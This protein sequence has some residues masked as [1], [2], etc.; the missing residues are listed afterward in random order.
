MSG[1]TSG[2][3]LRALVVCV[4]AV[5]ATGEG[6]TE[7]QEVAAA[8]ESLK[9]D[10]GVRNDEV[11]E[12]VV[13]GYREA[14]K[15]ALA[16]KRTSDVMVDA[17]NAE[18]VAKFPDSNLAESLQRLPGIAVDRDNGEGRTITVRGLG[19]DFTRVRLNGLE[20]LATAAAPDSGGAPNRSRGFD[21]N[22]F[23]S[24]LFS[25][26]EVRKTASADT[27]EGSLGATVD[28]QTPRPF[29]FKKDRYAFSAQDAYYEIG[30][31][32]RPRIAALMSQTW[33]DN[34]LGGAVS[35]A[36]NDRRSQINRY[37]RQ[38][39]SGDFLNQQAFTGVTPARG[40]FSAPVG[41]SFGNSVT[42]PSAIAA[43][44][45]SDPAAYA[46]LFPGPPYS[47]PGRFD[48]SI[49]RVPGL[50][51]IE[52]QNLTESRIGLTG[53]LQWRPT[54]RTLVSLDG[55]FSR[56]HQKSDISQIVDIGMNRNNTAAAYNVA[57][58]GTKV[59]DK[60]NLY[61]LCNSRP[62]T[63]YIA[64]LDCGGTEAVP[65]GVFP[66]YNG[67]TGTSFSTNPHNLDPYDYYNNPGSV[68]YPGAAAVAA[69]QFIYF[70]DALIGRPSTDVL[71]ANVDEGGTADYLMLRNMDARSATD[72][73]YF[74]TK[75]TQVSLN[76]Q[77]EITATLHADVL[78]GKSSSLNHNQAFLVEF[79]R[80]DSPEP[81]VYDERARGPMPSVSYGFDVADPNNWSIV[82]GYS[83][84]RHFERETDN[85]YSG[86]HLNFKWQ[87]VDA[88]AMEF[89][90]TRRDYKFSANEFRRPGGNAET[91]NP[92]LLELGVSAQAL[93]R[94]YN[95]GQGLQVPAGT[96]RSF[97]APDINAF[98]SILG[99]DCNCV[100][101]WGDWR[102]TNLTTPGNQFAVDELDNSYFVQ[103][104]WD[105]EVLRR[106]FFGNVGVRYAKTA[107]TSDGYTTNVTATG[108]RPLEASNNYHDLLPSLNAAY[109]L[110]EELILR[111][112]V[113]KVMSRPLLSNLAPSITNLT[114][115]STTGTTGSLT[116][117][118]PKVNPFRAT[119]YDFSVEW[120]FTPG[121]L[122]SGA[123]FIK[124]VTNYPQVVASAGSIQDLFTAEEFAQFLQTQP[125]P[126]TRAWLTSGGPNG[127]PGIYSIL[128]FKDSPG[129]TIKGYELTYQQNLT[130]LPWYF[131]NLGVQLNYTH[132]SSSLS[133]ILDPG[134]TTGPAPRPQTT[135][136]GPF[137]G[138]S[139]I[140]SNATLFYESPR[141]S[142]RVSM[143][144][145][146]R[147]V[148]TYPIASGGCAP[149]A[150]GTGVCTTPLINDF[151]GSKATRTY[152]A[153]LTYNIGEH[154]TL[155]LEGLN[156]TA[157]T[158]DR[159]V[160]QADPIVAQYS[161][162]GRQYFAGFRFQ[163]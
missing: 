85:R 125:D 65:G 73:S 101:K 37:R 92:T 59:P 76:L 58:A 115:P 151:I 148:T 152:D 155:T 142:A 81:F 131:R 7:A 69:A 82:K 112:G 110:T 36:Y 97:F 86:G 83:V 32:H 129:G 27:D 47:T 128:Q 120:Y 124:K 137:I 149:G 108:P 14:L 84:L 49:V 91:L 116:I 159:W 41:T 122:L 140:T 3:G 46:A 130:F 153:E 61:P 90:W 145:R 99:F 50:I 95:F 34:R 54:D 39:G 88:L 154:L 68:G 18:D 147:Y 56:F 104:D 30:G 25:S 17:I 157:E 107:V 13:S 158:D 63:P 12:V 44:T 52:Q 144:Y 126:A 105:L 139:P 109:S 21:F 62:A 64:P 100:N 67:L 33:F 74:T 35:F 1:A 19:S 156:L 70:R 80:L 55:V 117:G 121:S 66:G 45:G 10:T 93:G 114:T 103:F 5:L 42:N 40:G 111:T 132:L 161:S 150:L 2:R 134:A 53:S 163:Y 79:D 8:V 38:P 51:N 43:L 113:A 123:Y 57:N 106:K 72:S 96:P 78:Y 143:A 9:N 146:G 138:A 60:R 77:Q 6:E 22:N 28:L 48:D 15:S 20:A 11:Q 26:L 162:P 127:G 94:V 118:N 16:L 89:G 4:G 160:Y 119:N 31:Y 102:I 75:F 29:D 135:Q 98:R 141:W 23:A 133:Y 136:N 71:A 87:M 24:D